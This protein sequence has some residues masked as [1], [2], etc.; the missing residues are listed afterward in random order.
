[1]TI[2]HL[3][4]LAVALMVSATASA[5]TT[6]RI[7]LPPSQNPTRSGRASNLCLT[8]PRTLKALVGADPHTHPEFFERRV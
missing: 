1:M 2:K 3:A 5:Q 4:V 8:I 6:K 7:L